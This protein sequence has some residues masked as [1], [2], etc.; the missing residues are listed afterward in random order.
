MNSKTSFHR[1]KQIQCHASFTNDFCSVC[2]YTC[3]CSCPVNTYTNCGNDSFILGFSS[4]FC[5]VS[6]SLCV[7]VSVRVCIHTA[8]LNE[9]IPMTHVKGTPWT[10]FSTSWG[11]MSI[12]VVP[13]HYSSMDSLVL[14]CHLSPCRSPRT[15]EAGLV[16]AVVGKKSQVLT[17]IWEARYPVQ[18]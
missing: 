17:L 1:M 15:V 5:L 18:C 12:T 2:L 11:T 7:Y 10:F 4:H 3:E 8:C 14:T 6:C 16:I 9:D 13:G